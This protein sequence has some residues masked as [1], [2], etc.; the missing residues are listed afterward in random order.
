MDK[1]VKM[2]IIGLGNMGSA[3]VESISQLSNCK[4][5]A[6]CDTNPKKLE[7]YKDRSFALFSTDDDFF[8]NADIDGVI[9]AVPHY[10]HI[11]LTLRALE[12]GWNVITE[13]PVSVQKSMALQLV[14]AQKKY[15]NLRIAAMFNQRTIPA[16]KKIKELIDKGELGE[17]RRVNWII[18]NWFRTQAYY[19][20]GGWRASWRGEGGGALIN[21]C[22][23]Q[24]DM[25]QWFFGMPKKVT[26]YMTFGKYHKIEVEDDVTAFLE[27][28]NGA[29]GVFITSTGEAPGTNRLEITGE[30]GRLV[31][32]NGTIEF[33]RNEIPM[34]EFSNTTK[35][36]FATPSVW[37]I[38]IPVSGENPHQHRDII[39]NFADSILNGTPLIAN[40][41]E[42]INGLELGNAMHLSKF[43]GKTV[44]LPLD[45]AEFDRQ[46]EK[47]IAE[48]DYVK[49]EVSENQSGLGNSFKS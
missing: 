49:P 29:T 44:E 26:A 45:T 41:T 8:A 33:K 2:G 27:Y 13:K 21:Q 42:G 17:I 35:E 28:P 30:R 22:P 11:P 36:S 25:M 3:H 23:H 19:N 10:D 5:T 9:I 39:E 20:S 6:V 34:S 24:L 18:T 40:A 43:L 14:D 31:Y 7:R 4:L 15:P 46:L 37:N 12:H 38:S 32:E 16:H 48:S 1:I 47:L